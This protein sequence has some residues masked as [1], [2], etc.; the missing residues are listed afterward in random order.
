M[1]TLILLEIGDH[2]HDVEIDLDE[3]SMHF[4]TGRVL[5]FLRWAFGVFRSRVQKIA[6]KIEVLVETQFQ[7]G[8]GG[9]SV[10]PSVNVAKVNRKTENYPSK[11]IYHRI[12]RCACLEFLLE[13]DRIL[14]YAIEKRCEVVFIGP[15][16]NPGDL[17]R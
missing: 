7:T 11:K 5:P 6:E 8:D 14:S 3:Y 9:W 16:F 4:A 15:Y 17:L 13:M 1:R 10:V 12:E 2:L